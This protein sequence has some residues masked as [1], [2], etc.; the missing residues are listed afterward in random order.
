MQ[1]SAPSSMSA[2]LKS[3]HLSLGITPATS[4]STPVF[5]DCFPM[6]SRLPVIL[7]TTRSTFPSTAGAGIPKAMDAMAP[8]V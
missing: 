4:R 5:T 8:A 3:P 1:T 2:W 7:A 6:S